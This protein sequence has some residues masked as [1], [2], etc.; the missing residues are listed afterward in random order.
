M[1][2]AYFFQP[3]GS[4]NSSL[5]VPIRRTTRGLEVEGDAEEV[6]DVRDGDDAFSMELFVFD[7]GSV[8]V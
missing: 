7:V 5:L 4:S 6:V 3:G 8:A 1:L 2:I